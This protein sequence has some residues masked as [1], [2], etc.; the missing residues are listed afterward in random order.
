MLSATALTTALAVSLTSNQLPRQTEPMAPAAVL[1][2][3]PAYKY[4]PYDLDA[5]E[6]MRA[7]QCL[8][9][10]TLRRGGR[11][12]KAVSSKGLNGTEAELHTAAES[13]HWQDG[14]TPLTNAWDKDDAWTLA[15][16]RELNARVDVWESSLDIP[17]QTTPPG[18][19]VAGFEW[20][21]DEDNP[22]STIGLTAGL[23]AMYFQSESDLYLTDQTPVANKE[24]VDAVNAIAAARYSEDRY[25]DY[26]ERQALD[27][28]SLMHRMYADD[29]RIFLQH[30][31]FPTTA[32][33]PDTMEFRLDVEALKARFASCTTDN[34]HDPNNVLGAEVVQASVEWQNEL[35]GQKTQRAVIMDAEEKA[36]GHLRV[37]AQAM[38][39]A[40]GQS[41]IASR[42]T[43]WQAHWLKQA[44][45]STMFYPTAT[46]FAEVKT[47]IERA[48][49]R[50]QG[51]VFV[52]G[53]AALAA[54]VEAA[55]AD[56]AKG[57]AYAVA[58]AAGLPR[59]RGLMYGQQA[60]QISKASAAAAQAAFKATE[61]AAN[62]T[63]A[64][65]SDSKTLMALAETQAHA[66]KAEFRRKAAE[67]A[68]AQAKAA[69][70]GAAHQAKL[71]AEN[72][73]K[74]KDAEGRA[75]AAEAQA[76]TAAADADAKRKKAESEAAY[77]K[78]QKELADAER[79]KA[80]KANST[81]Q[82]ERQ[83][84]A[85][86]LSAA[87]TAGNTASLKKDEALEAEG[88][89]ATARD[90]ALRAEGER[91]A[92]V[93]RAYALEA[94]ADADAGTSAAGASRA[95]AT[96]A[97]TA[98]DQATIAA[99]NARSAANEATTA[100]ANARAAATRA[101]GA[102]KR[103]QAAADAAK[104][105]VAV[106]EAAVKKATAAAADAIDAAQ[107][108]KTNA[109][110]AKVEAATAREKAS[111]AR[112]HATSARAEAIAA[113]AAAVKTAGFAVST[114]Q[115]ASAARDS[116]AQVI[117]PANDAIELGSPYKETDSSAGLAVLIGQGAKDSAAQQVAVAN[118]KAAQ[119]AKAAVE[120]KALAAKASGDAKAAAEAAAQAAEYAAAAAKSAAAA[121]VSAN[122]ADASAKSAKKAEAN[123]IAYHE[124][125]KA[126]AEA[127]QRAADTAGDHA[128]QA[129]ASAT[130]AERDASSAR[131][132]AGAAETDASTAREVADRAEQDATTAEAAVS[133]A[134]D[135]AQEAQ[136]VATRTEQAQ[137]DTNQVEQAS[138]DG[139]AGAAE[140]IGVPYGVSTTAS[141]DGFCTGTN[142]CDYTVDY[143]VTG[144]MLYF[145]LVCQFPDVSLAE[146]VGDLDV[147]Y[148]DSAPIDITEQRKVHVSGRD[149]T[150]AMLQGF[151][152][153]LTQD[154]VDCWNH[155]V[156]GCLWAA[157]VVT[158]A[159]IGVAA[160][161]IRSIR[162]AAVAGSGVTEAVAAAES[163]G[164]SAEAAA[165]AARTART[166]AQVTDELAAVKAVAEAHGFTSV[167]Q[168][169]RGVLWANKLDNLALMNP[170]H[171]AKLKQ[172]GFTRS[173]I[174]TVFAYYDKI[175]KVTPQNPS[176]GPRADL[177][178]YILKNW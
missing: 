175:R 33:E 23:A 86:R 12:L 100:A 51:R 138:T 9:N 172:A 176:A 3:V 27:A 52:A 95:A 35:S 79:A 111:E 21:Y 117:K 102:H 150:T 134:Q 72:A 68:E 106:T 61:T 18:Y 151:A 178:G 30:G 154:F 56:K 135:S 83:T 55:R 8:L 133:R 166:A 146:C 77:A 81:A 129:D 17:A 113:G 161:L 2:D 147:Q 121:Q 94:K 107:A 63:R 38:G 82:R 5:D 143:R 137:R 112:G 84:A 163:A 164:L 74:A 24:S 71:A 140:V 169:G 10:L 168:L 124:Q 118:A 49:E 141:S 155:K 34:P 127:A 145:V 28:M 91:D 13:N 92:A 6:R 64:S 41:L 123:T 96:Q 160:K 69:A 1:T 115:A 7:E 88:R 22:F 78:T 148:V 165:G 25:E 177:M 70:E 85:D 58:D 20:I 31:G 4:N 76:K 65:A 103:A 48:R 132:A 136:D 67:E 60:V 75:K 59:G 46:E 53:R 43:D 11:E 40:L 47:N 126:D 116:A 130:D 42:L 104:A 44:P 97:R 32:P 122:Q 14:N 45:S 62:A 80:A 125:A 57:E 66:M 39:E 128:A 37:A 174:E 158:P 93:A 159:V 153:G 119:A 90:G 157:A 54:Q 29:A 19:T 149:L 89:A 73:T 170:A 15:K 108:A 99:G 131:A 110:A 105:D 162:V 120:A 16:F 114:A 171:I 87:Q 50:A 109:A 101:E 26:E 142:G 156:S 152:R 36:S 98:A 139:M 173:Q 144:T 167:P